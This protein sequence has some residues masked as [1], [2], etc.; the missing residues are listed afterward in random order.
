MICDGAMPVSFD[1]DIFS[2]PTSSQPWANTLR[3]GSRPAA[4]SM[5]GQYTAWN[6]RM[7]LPTRLTS[8][9][10]H[11]GEPPALGGPGLGAVADRRGVV[12]Q[13]V[14]PDVDDLAV[15]PRQRDAPADARPG[16][17]DVLQPLPD[18]RRHLVVG[19]ARLDRHR[20]SPRSGRVSRSWN[21]DSRKNQFC[22]CSCS[23]GRPCMGQT[24]WPSNSPSPSS[25]VAGK[26]ELLAAHAVRT[27][28]HRVVDVAV[29]ADRL[30]EALHAL[31]VP[32]LGG[33]DEVVVGRVD[34][35][36]D[37]EPGVRHEPVDPLLRRHPAGSP[38]R[39]AT[40]VPCSSTPVRNH[41]SSPR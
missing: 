10:Q 8:G 18:E 13:G 15:V 39:A 14:E 37:R 25:E 41:T 29:V 22:S 3:G 2:P 40:F 12:E 26:L 5:A 38:P 20:G 35:V 19:A 27:L 30:P 17:R 28:V 7:S 31:L 24:C 16:H 1:F 33:A 32:G 21:A 34:G 11:R 6:R 4:I 9:G 23:T 36:E